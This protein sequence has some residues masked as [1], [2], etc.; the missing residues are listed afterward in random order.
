MNPQYLLSPLFP[1]IDIAA[2]QSSVLTKMHL[3]RRIAKGKLFLSRY[4][5]VMV[6]YVV[7]KDMR[8]LPT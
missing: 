8:Q 2:I 5:L 6:S 4:F 3:N 1:S 7:D